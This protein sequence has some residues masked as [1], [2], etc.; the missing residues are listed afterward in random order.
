MSVESQTIEATGDEVQTWFRDLTDGKKDFWLTI[1]K[2]YKRRDITRD[3]IT[4]LV[5]LGLRSTGGCYQTLATKFHM[6]RKE[7]RRMMDFLRRNDCLLDF[8]PYRQ[9]AARDTDS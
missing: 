2:G 4:A 1:H 5:D 7:Y 9:A 6:K 8:R 3:K